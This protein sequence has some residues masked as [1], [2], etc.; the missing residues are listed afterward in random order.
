MDRARKREGAVGVLRL[1]RPRETVRRE[2]FLRRRLGVPPAFQTRGPNKIASTFAWRPIG[3]C[4]NRRA[5]SRE[6]KT[7][8]LHRRAGGRRSVQRSIRPAI[9]RQHNRGDPREEEHRGGDI[10]AEREKNER[11]E[12]GDEGESRKFFHVRKACALKTQARRKS[13]RAPPRNLSA[14]GIDAQ[15]R[16]AK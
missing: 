2:G 11:D 16:V 8:A 3:R 1:Q 7:F 6:S 15:Q 5:L 14:S 13:Y 4:G 10:E 12:R 9:I